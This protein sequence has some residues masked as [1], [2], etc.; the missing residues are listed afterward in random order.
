MTRLFRSKSCG[1]VGLTE[2]NSPPP[3][4]FFHHSNRNDDGEEDE[5]EDEEEEFESDTDTDNDNDDGG[6][7]NIPG[8]PLLTPFVVNPGSRF[9]GVNRDG[10]SDH[11]ASTHHHQNNNQFQIL[12]VLVSAL[13]KSLVTCNVERED[14][15]S[16]D[17]SWPTEVR[18]VS[19]VTFDRFSGFLGLPTELEPEVTR[20]APSARSVCCIL[21]CFDLQHASFSL[22]IYFFSSYTHAATH[23]LIY[24]LMRIIF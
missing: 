19:H 5:D 1:L 9:G 6:Y 2:F 8:N 15:S 20:K 4:P 24:F 16:M 12:G 14:A 22:F 3:S 23:T 7:D 17:I 10:Q 18:H 21:I 11:S 13:R